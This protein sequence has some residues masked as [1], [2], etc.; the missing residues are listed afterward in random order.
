[1]KFIHEGQRCGLVSGRR[2]YLSSRPPLKRDVARD[3]CNETYARLL[4]RL[5]PLRMAQCEAD[6]VSR[7]SL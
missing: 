7:A 4:D 6:V 3:F 2:S 5:A 1:M